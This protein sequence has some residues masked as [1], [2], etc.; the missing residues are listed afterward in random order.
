MDPSSWLPWFLSLWLLPPYNI[1]S[2]KEAYTRCLETVHLETPALCLLKKNGDSMTPKVK[3]S[4][5]LPVI[6]PT[7]S[8]TEE[9]DQHMGHRR[10]HRAPVFTC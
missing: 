5:C 1:L 8:V 2:L 6:A 10:S 9:Q 3:P 4:R 7:L